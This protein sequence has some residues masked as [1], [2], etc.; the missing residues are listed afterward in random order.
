METEAVNGI[1]TVLNAGGVVGVLVVV[2][3]LFLRGD[4]LPRKIWAELTE[5]VTLEISMKIVTA[6]QGRLKDEFD[7]VRTEHKELKDE[8]GKVQKLYKEVQ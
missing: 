7:V 4:L 6:V 3:V 5:K 8:F 2:L 1:M